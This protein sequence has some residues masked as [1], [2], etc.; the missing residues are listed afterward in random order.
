MLDEPVERQRLSD[1]AFERIRTAIITGELAPG[2]RV[3]DADLSARLGLSRTPVREALMR[4]ANAGLIEARPGVHTRI[5][6]LDRAEVEDTLAVLR[7]L[8]ELAVSTAVPRLTTEQLAAMRQAQDR[9]IQAAQSEDVMAALQADDEFHGVIQDAANNPVLRRLT[10]QTHPVV[11]RILYRKF[12]TLLG[13]QNTIDHHERL[14]AHC[15]AGEAE[16]AAR[17]SAEHWR[18]LGGLIGQLFEAEAFAS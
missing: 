10:D 12:S 3:R 5:S 17:L 4:L 7:Q 1:V 16:E 9:F 15:A 11:H 6:R 8:D 18:L 14:L 13:G 2:E